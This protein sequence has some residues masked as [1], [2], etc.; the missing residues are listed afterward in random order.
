MDTFDD[1]VFEQ[2]SEQTNI[3]AFQQGEAN[4]NTDV[5]QIR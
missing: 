5:V 3:Y 4:L 2:V 1:D